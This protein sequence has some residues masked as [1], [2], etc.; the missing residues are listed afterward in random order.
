MKTFCK[1]SALSLSSQHDYEY[2]HFPVVLHDNS[3]VPASL[4]NEDDFDRRRVLCLHLVHH[5]AFHDDHHEDA[6][7]PAAARHRQAGRMLRR[8]ADVPGRLFIREFVDIVLF[9]EV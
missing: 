2:A 8:R 4:H 6:G 7:L 5:E 1:W 9:N 3:N